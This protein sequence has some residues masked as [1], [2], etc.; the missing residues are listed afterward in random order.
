V[1]ITVTAQGEIRDVT[2]T[3]STGYAR[4][5]QACVDE[6]KG[7][8]MRPAIRDGKAVSLTKEIPINSTLNKPESPPPS[9]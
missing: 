9:Q 4:L 3:K 8:H 5:D 7:A 6:F 2:L 1:K